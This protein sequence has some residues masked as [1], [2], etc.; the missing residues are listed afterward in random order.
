[1]FV[2]RLF[3]KRWILTT[4][5]AFAG[6]L[7]LARLGIWQLDRLAERRV[8]NA[9]VTAA[10]ARP[11]LDLNSQA[12]PAELLDLEYAPVLVQG[13]YR[14][15]QQVALRNQMF[16]EQPGAALLTPLQIAGTQSFVLVNRG[17]IPEADFLAGMPAGRWPQF[18]EPGL[19]QLAGVIRLAQVKGDFGFMVDA[20][21][22]PGERLAAWNLANL[23]Q[24]AAQISLPGELL[25]IYLQQTP[26]GGQNAPAP[27]TASQ[28]IPY[29]VQ[30]DLDLSEGSHAGY[31]LQWFTFAALL[32]FGYPF[33]I[34]NEEKAG[35]KSPPESS[36]E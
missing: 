21:P 34:L 18:D 13:E 31:A 19:Q 7:V 15:D 1:M 24:M 25:P 20:T 5:L 36:V 4:L 10:M 30:P 35:K 16:N 23:P 14:F 28:T 3:S 12:L 33:F 6:V 11:P 9:R 27:D 32:F 2:L 29:R 22:A 8:F 17:W 26:A